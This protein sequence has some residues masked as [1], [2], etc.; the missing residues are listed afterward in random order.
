MEGTK[1]MG[2]TYEKE[3]RGEERAEKGRVAEKDVET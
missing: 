3:R 2:G 1:D